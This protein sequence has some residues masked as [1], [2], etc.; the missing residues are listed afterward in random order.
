MEGLGSAVES[1]VLGDFEALTSFVESLPTLVPEILSDIMEGGEEAVSIVEELVTNPGAALTVI[2]SGV[3]SVFSVITSG[4]V[5]VFGDITHFF[6]CDIG[7]DC[8]SSTVNGILSSCSTVMDQ[9][10][11][12]AT[13]PADQNTVTTATTTQPTPGMGATSSQASQTGSGG[14][15]SG[16]FESNNGSVG[17]ALSTI[18]RLNCIASLFVGLGL[19]FVLL[20]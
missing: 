2:E 3:V 15:N 7:G 1:E 9:Y 19:G 5:S 16:N 10:S 17:N 13:S 8:P 6:G 18:S 14:A 11:A 20:L 4:V 12:T